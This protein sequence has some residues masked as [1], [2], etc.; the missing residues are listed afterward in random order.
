MAEVKRKQ[1]GWV[2]LRMKQRTGIFSTAARYHL[3]LRW[4]RTRWFWELDTVSLLFILHL[5][6]DLSQYLWI[7]GPAKH[8]NSQLN[9]LAALCP[10]DTCIFFCLLCLLCLKEALAPLSSRGHYEPLPHQDPLRGVQRLQPGG[11]SP[12]G[13][14]EVPCLSGSQGPQRHPAARTGGEK[15]T[16]ANLLMA[17]HHQQLA[18]GILGLIVQSLQVC[19]EM[20]VI[21]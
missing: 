10:T 20:H 9:M 6:C 5:C 15:H 8:F 3:L 2:F 19:P 17:P 12:P 21:C 7:L 11:R 13:S 16:R 4:M 1:D 14:E 18:A